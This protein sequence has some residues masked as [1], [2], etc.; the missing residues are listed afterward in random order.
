MNLDGP[1]EVADV[2]EEGDVG[3]VAEV[4]VLV[5]EAVL[6]LLDVAPRHDGDLLTCLG[7]CWWSTAR[8]A[9]G[10]NTAGDRRKES[11]EEE[12]EEEEEIKQ[13]RCR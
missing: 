11:G 4:E 10:R 1:R 5:G 8:G 9:G 2:D 6:E 12:E 7:A 13:R 3:V